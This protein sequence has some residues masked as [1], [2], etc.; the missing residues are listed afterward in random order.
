MIPLRFR[1]LLSI[2]RFTVH[3]RIGPFISD[4]KLLEHWAS[5]I[6]IVLQRGIFNV[7][8]LWWWFKE[9]LLIV[10]LINRLWRRCVEGSLTSLWVLSWPL[11]NFLKQGF[12]KPSR[13]QVRMGPEF[14]SEMAQFTKIKTSILSFQVWGQVLLPFPETRYTS[15]WRH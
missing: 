10:S 3:G 14:P 6:I 11:H 12:R 2:S 5:V 4:F 13:E 8:L 9:N 15:W 1:L 7:A